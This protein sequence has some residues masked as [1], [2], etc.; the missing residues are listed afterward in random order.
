MFLVSLK[1]LLKNKWLTLCLFLGCFLIVAVASSIPTYTAGIFSKVLVKEM[2]SAQKESELYPG[3]ISINA[4]YGWSAQ[5]KAHGFKQYESNYKLINDCL[6]RNELSQ[7]GNINRFDTL[8]SGSYMAYQL[9]D[10][11]KMNNSISK[12]NRI[13]GTTKIED[14]I[15]IVKGE[16]YKPGLKDGCYEVIADAK[17]LKESKLVVGKTYQFA[18]SKNNVYKNKPY[19]IKI[20]GVYEMKNPDDPFWFDGFEKY[21][22]S[23]FLMDYNTLLN[24]MIKNDKFLITNSSTNLIYDYHNISISNVASTA[25]KLED[26][27]A[28]LQNNNT[29]KIPIMSKLVYYRDR[30]AWLTKLILLLNIP[31]CLILLFYIFTMAKLFVGYDENE[32]AVL[33]SRGATTFQVVKLYIIE[34]SLISIIALL[35]GI[36]FGMYLAGFIGYSN[37]FLSFVNRTAIHS[38]L[39]LPIILYALTSAAVF[40]LTSLVPIL[41]ACKKNILSHK[42]QRNAK[43]KTPL[44]KLACLDIIF[45]GISFYGLY[46]YNNENKALLASNTAKTTNNP[47]IFIMSSLFIIGACLFALRI[48]PYLIKFIHWCGKKIWPAAIHVSMINLSRNKRTG[49]LLVLF[50]AF[51]I[52]S[53]I[54]NAATARSINKNQEDQIRLSNGADI[55]LEI[56]RT[57]DFYAKINEDITR[58][59]Y[60]TEFPINQIKNLKGVQAV[61]KVYSSSTMTTP[62]MQ[63]GLHMLS[64][65]PQQFSQ[66]VWSRDDMNPYHINEYLNALAENPKG[67]FISPEL[68]KKEEKKIGDT[69]FLQDENFYY[70]RVLQMTIL[71]TIDRLPGY[72][73]FRTNSDNYFAL[74]NFDYVFSLKTGVPYK[75]WIKLDKDVST[76]EFY[77]SISDNKLLLNELVNTREQVIENVKN[78]PNIQGLNGTLSLSFILSLVITCTGLLLYWVIDVKSRSLQFS[79]LRSM[80][81]SKRSLNSMLAFEQFIIAGFAIICGVL[82]GG[83]AS[84]LFVHPI[85]MFLNVKSQLLPFITLIQI[86]DYLRIFV[87]VI[88]LL[89][90][91][92]ATIMSIVNR[93]NIASTL[94]LG[95][96]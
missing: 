44:W 68:L 35:F 46:L 37:G 70:P 83:L 23:I 25:T 78:N 58:P 51:T 93:L 27:A 73:T 55:V 63:Q 20:T 59:V 5:D 92:L 67:C 48:Y 47:L 18:F 66:V 50:L 15:K 29:V 53:G 95:E 49:S 34:F 90:V 10:Q 21:E 8:E 16:M 13:I 91:C 72:E 1:K 32:I 94:K 26:I 57:A 87:V 74:T 30:Q 82:I 61:S 45:L 2:E 12:L 81:V 38:P 54:F 22:Q 24:T 41:F 17:S 42:Q 43:T 86:G 28:S 69:I 71:G 79:V 31:L 56:S 4:K 64:V 36:P 39:S 76:K 7:L 84:T 40:I 96:D 65:Q 33:K 9:T 6:S 52:S 19:K 11:V 88:L 89:I 60:I 14:Y 3:V 80:G 85:S 77:D 75:H 62:T